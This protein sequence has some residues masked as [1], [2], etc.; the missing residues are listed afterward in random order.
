MERK[1]TDDNETRGNF[2]MKAYRAVPSILLAGLLA[3]TCSAVTGAG[4]AATASDRPAWPYTPPVP[5][6]R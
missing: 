3:G 5:R 1:I 4:W 2:A 6:S